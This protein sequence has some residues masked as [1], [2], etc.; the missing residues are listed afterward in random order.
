MVNKQKRKVLAVVCMI[1]ALVI[2]S[3][4]AATNHQNDVSIFK[5]V[6]SKEVSS[7]KSES[8]PEPSLTQL[9]N[10]LTRGVK[11]DQSVYTSVNGIVV[12]GDKIFVSDETGKK[13]F[14]LSLKGEIEET[15]TSAVTVNGIATDGSYIYAL[16]GGLDGAVVK[17]SKNF[18][19]LSVTKVGHTP[20][21]IAFAKGKAYVVNRFS[22]DISVISVSDMTVISTV[23]ADGREPISDRKSVV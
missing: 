16:T 19:I 20:C 18:D 9:S 5:D 2:V 10:S 22:S 4:F 15:Y 14:R 21:D 3:A 11:G 8:M 17:L 1:V 12:D 23:E 7:E 6:F 13:I